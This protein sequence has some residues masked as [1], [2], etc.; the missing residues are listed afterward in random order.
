M[1]CAPSHAQQH[2]EAFDEQ[3]RRALLPEETAARLSEMLKSLADPTRVRILSLL[4]RQ[5]LCVMEITLALGMSQPAISHHLR[6]LRQNRLVRAR[7]QGKHVMYSLY[8][9]HIERLFEQILAH[10]QD[11]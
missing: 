9:E 8:D 1:T 10:A 6:V 3:I 2:L 11:G 7:R 5:P 4:L